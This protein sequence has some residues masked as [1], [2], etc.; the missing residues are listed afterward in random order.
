MEI[1]TKK[2]G[3]VWENAPDADD[4]TNAAKYLKL[5]LDDRAVQAATGKFRKATTVT[6][7]AKDVLRASRLPLLGKDDPQ[8]ALDLKRIAKKKKLSPVLLIRGD[9]RKGVPMMVADGYHRICASYHW[10][11]D[12]PVACRVVSL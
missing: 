2:E 5:V 8:V 11:E 10:D 12:C 3:S 4:L 9:A 1:V 7:E 6:Y